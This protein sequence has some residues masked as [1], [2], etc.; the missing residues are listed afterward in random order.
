MANILD[1]VPPAADERVQYGSGKF[2]FIDIRTPSSKAESAIMMIHGGFWRNRYDLLHAGH[3]CAALAQAGCVTCN[4]E[5]RRVGDDGGGWPGSLDDLRTAFTFVNH[6]YSKN[7]IVTGH[8]AGGQLALALAAYEPKVRCAISLAG[9]LDLHRAHELH[10]SND[11]VA[12]FLGGTPQSVSDRYREASPS[13][14]NISVQQIVITGDADADVPPQISRDYVKQKSAAG[15]NVDLIEIPRA[16][17]FDLIDP[18]TPAFDVIRN[19]V[20]RV[21]S[22]Q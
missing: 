6:H 14:L 19:A 9:V 22:P 4:V 18:H 15:E 1:I 2:Q 17:H 10:L 5:Y 20:A 16:D 8:S 3:L 13:E 21:A 12:N 7:V 11:A